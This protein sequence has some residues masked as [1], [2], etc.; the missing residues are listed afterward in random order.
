MKILV[1]LFSLFSLN[2]AHASIIDQQPE[3]SRV[4]DP[5][6]SPFKDGRA[7]LE[8][9]EKTNRR[10]MIEVGGNWC[11][12]C[13][14]FER[15]LHKNA[16]IAKAFFSTFVLLKVNVSDDNNNREF[17]S[18]FTR[19]NGYPYIYITENNGKVVYANDM[20]EM[21]IKGRPDR[22]KLIRFLEKWKLPENQAST[23]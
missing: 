1:I 12:Y 15:Y 13:E 9:A 21:T 3:Y 4:Y 14:I 11:V 17:L 18:N 22:D 5:K 2:L 10:V 16:D 20:R 8:L 23:K 6:R 19:V 7:A